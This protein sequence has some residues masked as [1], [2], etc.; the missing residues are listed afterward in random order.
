MDN[1]TLEYA[2]KLYEAKGLSPK[3][4]N[5]R[6]DQLARFNTIEQVRVYSAMIGKYLRYYEK[7]SPEDQTKFLAKK[8]KLEQLGSVTDVVNYLGK[9]Q[10]T[11][12]QVGMAESALGIPKWFEQDKN[13]YTG[14]LREEK[15]GNE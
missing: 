10:P 2:A 5:R 11:A 12:T 6:V 7:L 9:K 8:E 1:E 3:E 4:V 15:N 13:P 14:L